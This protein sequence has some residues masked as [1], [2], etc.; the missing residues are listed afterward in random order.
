MLTSR[1][2]EL[3]CAGLPFCLIRA[4]GGTEKGHLTA[5]RVRGELQY[6]CREHDPGAPRR[7]LPREAASPADANAKQLGL[8]GAQGET[9]GR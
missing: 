3:Q 7:G 4:I 1:Y 5:R 9:D 8:F 2:V 6:F